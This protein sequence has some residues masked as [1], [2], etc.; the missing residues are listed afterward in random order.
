[1]LYDAVALNEIKRQGEGGEIIKVRWRLAGK[2]NNMKTRPSRGG[3][4]LTQSIMRT[5]IRAA[6]FAR[7]RASPVLHL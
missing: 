4:K 5:V 2:D 6:V 7:R 1:V 3:G